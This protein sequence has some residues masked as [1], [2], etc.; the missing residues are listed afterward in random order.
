MA[1]DV[2]RTDNR[3]IGAR[4]FTK[5]LV[6]VDFSSCSE[7]AFRV[8]LRL[9]RVF[10]SELVL[11]HVVDTKSLDTLNM[12]GLALPSEEAAQK[13]RLRHQA[14]LNARR[15]L[16]LEEAKGLTIRRLILE[17]SPFVEIA[18][19]VRSQKVD[20][21][22]MGSYGGTTGSVEK[23]FFGSTAEK[24]VRA[25][26]CPVLCVPLTGQLKAALAAKPGRSESQ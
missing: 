17:G 14:R 18:R 4:Q 19:T 23:I 22:V 7:E 5:I 20:L 3:D 6:P 26:N 8:A 1:E 21:V 25:A 9:T 11:L 15:L 12:L 2:T 13:K 10:Q 16:A 24:V